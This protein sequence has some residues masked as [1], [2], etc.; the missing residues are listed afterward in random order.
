MFEYQKYNQYFAQ[1]AGKMEE[2][3]KQELVELGAKNVKS[4]Y[5]GVYFVADFKL[6]MK[7]T[8]LS[9][10]ATRIYAPLLTFQCHSDRYLKNTAKKKINWKE[11]L[12]NDMTFAVNASV[13][14]SKIKHSK[15]ASL[16]VKDSIADYFRENSGSRPNVDVKN[17][18]VDFYLRV[19]KNKAVLSFNMSGGSLHRRGYRLESVSA[20]MQ[21]TLAAAVVRVSGWQGEKPLWDFM[22]GSGTIIAEALMRCCNIPAGYLRENFSFK[23]LPDFDDKEWQKIKNKENAKIKPLKNG[24]L[25]ATDIS[26]DAVDA[27]KTNLSVLPGADKVVFNIEDFSNHVN[28]FENGYVII[29]PP[30]GIRMGNKDT[31]MLLYQ[32]IGDFLK[33][34]CKNSTAFI[35]VGDKKM[36]KHIGL[37]P[38]KRIP[39][40]NGKLE[41]ELLEIKIY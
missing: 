6:A 28:S 30:Y 12:S 9:T 20:P 13:A 33:Q 37:K 36:A 11:L 26:R 35:Y 8:Y 4:T 31:V 41:G 24:K 39:L 25:F 21:E 27:A 22:C 2:L 17:P 7:I 32:T 29:N 10:L 23:H 5:R 15:Y 1:T 16:C 34:K 40:V 18:D 19:D 38:S 3:C 14:N